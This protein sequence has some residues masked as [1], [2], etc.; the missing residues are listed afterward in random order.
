MKLLVPSS[1]TFD[2]VDHELLLRKLSCY[3]FKVFT[4][5][6]GGGK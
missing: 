4:L 1:S 2:A 5:V 6:G 3:K